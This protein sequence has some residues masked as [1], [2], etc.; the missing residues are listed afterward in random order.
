MTFAN[1][2][3]NARVRRS[4]RACAKG[5]TA[6]RGD[7]VMIRDD[8]QEAL[9]KIVAFFQV[10]DPSEATCFV[11]INPLLQHGLLWKQ[12]PTAQIV[13]VVGIPNGYRQRSSSQRLI[14]Q[15]RACPQKQS[16]I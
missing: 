15:T 1:A 13:K 9:A 14:E 10:G 12:S 7:L 4:A 11:L 8:G 16:N 6:S 2:S 3:Y 5:F